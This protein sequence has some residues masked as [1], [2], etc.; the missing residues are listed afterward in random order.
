MDLNN[1]YQN[2]FDKKLEYFCNKF[3]TNKKDFLNLIDHYSEEIK[4]FK[5]DFS[6]E[7]LSNNLN[8]IRNNKKNHFWFNSG[9]LKLST[10]HSFKGWE[11]ELLFLI[12]EPKYHSNSEFEQSFD[13]IIYTGLTR[14]RSNLIILNYGN[15]DYHEKLKEIVD[16]IK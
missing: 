11:S 4:Q 7:K 6:P 2:I 5:S 12:I 14:S 10:V 9:T 16:K 13:E 15:R 3:K 1:S 8:L